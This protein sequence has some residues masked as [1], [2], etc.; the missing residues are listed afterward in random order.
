MKKA[1]FS[2]KYKDKHDGEKIQGNVKVQKIDMIEQFGKV[3][4]FID[5]DVVESNRTVHEEISIPLKSVKKLIKA[6]Q[7]VIK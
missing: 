7:K 5:S 1:K 4:V 2:Y 3:F 6:L